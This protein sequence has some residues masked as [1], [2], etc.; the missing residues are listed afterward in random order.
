MA[1]EIPILE[2]SAATPNAA[3]FNAE[4]A[5][6]LAEQGRELNKPATEVSI[7][8]TRD[9]LEELRTKVTKEKT[10]AAVKAAEEVEDA[11]PIV[12]KKDSP[13][14]ASNDT[15]APAKT[16]DKTA[17]VPDKSDA[18]PS[19]DI[20]SGINLPPN[21]KPKSAEAFAAVKSKALEEISARDTKLAELEKKL[22]E[23]E[24]KVKNPVP[25]EIHKELEELRTFRAKL[26]VEADPKFKSYDKEITDNHNFIYSQLLKTG[27]IT[28]ENIDQIKKYGGPGKVNLEKVF[29]VV[30]DPHVRRVIE[31]KLADEEMLHFK[32]EQA[33][34]ETKENVAGYLK[35]REE[36]YTKATKDHTHA[37]QKEFSSLVA[38]MDWTKTK[39]ASK[40]ADATVKAE[41]EAHNKFVESTKADLEA[42]LQDDTPQ[43]RAILLAGMGQLLNLQ[44]V[45]AAKTK[46]LADVRKQLSEATEKLEKIKSASRSRLPESSAPKNAKPPEP[47]KDEFGTHAGDA[48]E[49][50][51]KQILQEKAEKAAAA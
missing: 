45:D 13:K 44:R 30:N 50:I 24:E 18:S 43:M 29:E 32:K 21:I 4:I 39:T 6:T 7:A 15:L 37:T 8:E 51:R 2:L 42:A 35:E 47:K 19:A 28:Q 17:V 38:K 16:D 25:D 20:F 10:D 33:I 27:K 48:I 14:E 31:A 23:V 9:A 41:I 3:K 22:S 36:A 1:D 34:K 11:A 40:D 26:D 49:N 46:E 5:T 12:E